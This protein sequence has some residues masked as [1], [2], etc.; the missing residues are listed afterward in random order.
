MTGRHKEITLNFMLTG[1][2]KFLPD[3]A[4]GQ[5]KQRLKLTK[6]E[7]IAD[8]AAVVNSSSA[9]NI[10]QIVAEEDGSNVAVKHY[11]WN[12]FLSQWFREVPDVGRY[13]HFR[14]NAEKPGIISVREFASSPEQEICIFRQ[15][16]KRVN[17]VDNVL[18]DIMTPPGLSMKRQIYLNRFIRPYVRPE[19]QDLVCPEPDA[20]LDDEVSDDDV[21]ALA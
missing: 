17:I 4:F 21:P 1:H 16:K 5:I 2:T 8:I 14:F 7:C 10:A 15:K 13:H 6:V 12:D 9:M 11:A 18:P 19:I 20:S 3:G